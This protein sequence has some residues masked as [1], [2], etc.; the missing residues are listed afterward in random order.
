[1]ERFL[2]ACGHNVKLTWEDKWKVRKG[3]ISG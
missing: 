3:E 1:M 2:R